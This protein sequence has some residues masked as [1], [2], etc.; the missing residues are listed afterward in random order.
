M[1]ESFESIENQKSYEIKSNGDLIVI[2]YKDNPEELIE[3]IWSILKE[4]DGS[5]YRDDDDDYMKNKELKALFGGEELRPSI[6]AVLIDRKKKEVW[7]Q[8]RN[9]RSDKKYREEYNKKL[10]DAVK[11]VL[12]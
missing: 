2:R 11:K 4:V 3:D 5:V 6:Y 7:F 8:N 12:N 1:S 10:E 9:G